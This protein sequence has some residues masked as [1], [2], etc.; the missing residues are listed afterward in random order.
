MNKINK[1]N[2]NRF[3]DTENRLTAVRREEG[4]GLGEKGE[5][6]KQRKKIDTDNSIMVIARGKGRWREEEEGKRGKLSGQEA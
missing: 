1:Q 5:G 4:W 2:R 6:T 3:I